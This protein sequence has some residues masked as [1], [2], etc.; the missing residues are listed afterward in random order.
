M[1]K[2]IVEILRSATA[3]LVAITALLAALVGLIEVIKKL[4]RL[5]TVDDIMLKKTLKLL[6]I[7][8]VL[9]LI[10]GII[11]VGRSITQ[12]LNQSL[13]TAA[14][15]AYNKKD[16]KNAIEMAE[17]CIF[18][19]GPTAKRIQHEMESPNM[20][21][22]LE[23]KVSDSE[24][25]EILNRGILNDVGTCWWIKGISLERKG[26]TREAIQAYKEAEMLPYARTYDSSWDGF[27]SPAKSA[28]DRRLYLESR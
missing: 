19:F 13:T 12:P 24:K 16:Y 3:L 2:L 4:K 15:N 7:V 17:E 9:I 1:F 8:V 27:W 26:N 20:P 14:W 28:S 25:M 10:S 23:G 5:Y 22:P 11:F 18:N 6:Y 21:I